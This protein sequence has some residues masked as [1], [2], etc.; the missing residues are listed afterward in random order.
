MVILAQPWRGFGALMKKKKNEFLK[1]LKSLLLYSASLFK[2][3]F[4]NSLSKYIYFD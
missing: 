3:S 1:T 4:I 2:D